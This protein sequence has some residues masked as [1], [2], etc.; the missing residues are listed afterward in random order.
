MFANAEVRQTPLV[1]SL[2]EQL[3]AL[4]T[5]EKVIAALALMPGRDAA[6]DALIGA[7]ERDRSAVLAS[8]VGGR[9]LRPEPPR[10]RRPPG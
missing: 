9:A 6:I 10:I 3:R 8:M 5:T 7:I 4:E 2:R 1:G